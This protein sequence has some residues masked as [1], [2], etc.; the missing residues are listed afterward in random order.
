MGFYMGGRRPYGFDLKVTE[1]RN[2]KTKMLV[3]KNGET[4]NLKYIFET[5]SATSVTLR[6][7][8]DNLVQKQHSA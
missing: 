4:E 5:Y 6:R 1:I 3:P 7:L 8:M 2:V